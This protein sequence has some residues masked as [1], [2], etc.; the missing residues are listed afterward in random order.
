[1]NS[2]FSGRRGLFVQN[3]I[4]LAVFQ[5]K[6]FD[7][8]SE[9]FEGGIFANVAGDEVE[10]FDI[11]EPGVRER[12]AAEADI[13]HLNDE[14]SGFVHEGVEGEANA[15]GGASEER[16]VLVDGKKEVGG[17]AIAGDFEFDLF[18]DALFGEEG[19]DLLGGD[20]DG[21]G[22]AVRFGGG[23]RRNDFFGEFEFGEFGVESGFFGL[24]E[25]DGSKRGRI[26]VMLDP[27]DGADCGEEA[28][29]E[30]DACDDEDGFFPGSDGGWG[31]VH[32]S[33]V[34]TNVAIQHG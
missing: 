19:I 32:S 31:L 26:D 34:L 3:N 25:F 12:Y 14:F 23:F 2:E 10:A 7:A 29:G 13:I 5:A 15:E 6:V 21:A 33:V 30:D 11:A 24:A 4:H 20:G 17:D 8:G 22:I 27:P 1:M 16:R 9:A 28:A 18:T